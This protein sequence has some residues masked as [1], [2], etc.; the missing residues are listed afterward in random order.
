[1][2][3]A[4]GEV[5]LLAVSESLYLC[6]KDTTGLQGLSGACVAVWLGACCAPARSRPKG[7]LCETLSDSLLLLG[8]S[9][10]SVTSSK[11]G[12][13]CIPQAKALKFPEVTSGS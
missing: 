10:G 4:C 8:V 6:G 11:P 3:T 1:M 7:L 5:S 2:Q 12:L 9:Q 13:Y